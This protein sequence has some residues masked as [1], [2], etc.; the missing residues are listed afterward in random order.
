MEALSHLDLIN[1]L[2]QRR[3]A[4][5]THESSFAELEEAVFQ[6]EARDALDIDM[7]K[8]VLAPYHNT[9]IDLLDELDALQYNEYGFDAIDLIIDTVNPDIFA[10]LELLMPEDDQNEEVAEAS[11]EAYWEYKIAVFF[12]LVEFHFGIYDS[13]SADIY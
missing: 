1:L 2:A 11:W 6:L 8:A 12:A 9:A 5:V 7:L 4:L 13:Q 3:M 10:E